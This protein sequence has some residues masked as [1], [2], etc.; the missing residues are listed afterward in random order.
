M[1]VM[2][3]LPHTS[4][5]R[6]GVLQYR[7]RV[8]DDLRGVLGRTEFIHSFK[9]KDTDR[10]AMAYPAVHAKFEAMIAAARASAL[11]ADQ[12]RTLEVL[13][14]AGLVDEGADRFGPLRDGTAAARSHMRVVREVI[15]DQKPEAGW[16]ANADEVKRL[17]LAM[18]GVGAPKVTLRDAAKA[19]LKSVEASR[20][21]RDRAKQVNLA[22]SYFQEHRKEPDTAIEAI[23]RKDTA[24]FRDALAGRGWTPSTVNKR[25]KTIS[26]V[27]NHAIHEGSLPGIENP[28]AKVSVRDERDKRDL[29]DPLTVD[30]IAAVAD[31]LEGFNDEARLI[32]MLMAYTGARVGEVSGLDWADVRLTDK[33]PHIIIR[34]NEHR[35]IKTGTSRREV[36]LVGAALGAL[37]AWAAGRQQSGAVFPRYARQRDGA[38]SI[39][40][41]AMKKAKAWEKGRKV[42]HSL[43]HSHK[44]WMRRAAPVDMADRVHGHAS[45]GVARNYGG[46][47][48]LDI[49][50]GHIKAAHEAAGLEKIAFMPPDYFGLKI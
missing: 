41:Q 36:P 2:V 7:R 26:A 17:V 11:D 44:D 14:K 37:N 12:L 20:N 34:D 30:E 16:Q 4:W 43:R 29:R 15:A 40:L 25:L 42:V 27:I 48:L 28:F 9:T 49:V 1:G 31:R 33:T 8:P 10:M 47:Q 22:V 24:A 21:Y 50:A 23:S 46:D 19:Y 18:D 3:E 32:W 45:G 13:Q 6:S 5:N 39:L 38:S 35:T